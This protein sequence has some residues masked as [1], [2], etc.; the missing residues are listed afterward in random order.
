MERKRCRYLGY[1]GCIVGLV[2]CLATN[3]YDPAQY[4]LRH[5]L[6]LWLS[7][8]LHGTVEIGRLHGSLWQSLVLHDVVWRTDDSDIIARLPT[9]QLSYDLTALLSKRL[10][11]TQAVLSQPSVTLQQD[12]AGQWPVAVQRWLQHGTEQL[13]VTVQ[14]A[15]VSLQDGT[16]A[17]QR[18]TLPGVQRLT[19]VQG[20]LAGHVGP[21]GGAFHVQHLAMQAISDAVEPQTLQGQVQWHAGRIHVEGAVHTPGGG[22]TLHGEVDT[23]TTP[24]GYAGRLTMTHLDLSAWS[25]QP[26][27]RSDLNLQLQVAGAGD[28]LRTLRGTAH[29]DIQPSHLGEVILRP[30]QV[31][32]EVHDGRLQVHALHLDTSVVQGTVTGVLDTTGTSVLQY[33]CEADFQGL[34]ALLGLEALAGRV[35]LQGQIH[36]ARTAL[37][38]EGSLEAQQLQ[39]RQHGLQALQVTYG[40]TYLDGHPSLT[41]RLT[42]QR[43]TVAQTALGDLELALAYQGDTPQLQFVLDTALSPRARLHTQGS[44]SLA[45][46]EQRVV[47]KELAVHLAERTWR[48]VAPVELLQTAHEIRLSALRLTHAQETLECTGAFSVHALYDVTCRAAQLDVTFLGTFLPLPALMQGHLSASGHATGPWSA[49]R[50]RGDLTLRLPATVAGVYTEVEATGTYAPQQVRGVL[51]LRQEQR[52]VLTLAVTLPLALQPSA[53]AFQWHLLETPLALHMALHQPHVAALSSWVPGMAAVHGS[54]QGTLEVHGTPRA[55]TLQSSMDVLAL[56]VA[57]QVADVQTSVQAHA[58]FSLAT[59]R[60]GAGGVRVHAP[61]VSQIHA[62]QLRVAPGQGQLLSPDRSASVWQ[63]PELTLQAAGRLSA[64]QLEVTHLQVRSA[65]AEVRG[66]GVLTLP[67]YALQAHLQV[68]RLPLRML[69]QSLPATLPTV[70]QGEM[71]VRGSIA[72]PHVTLRLQYASAQIEGSLTL[73]RHA[74]LWRYTAALR[75]SHLPMALLWPDAAGSLRAASLRAAVHIEGTEGL[76]AQRRAAATIR[77]DVTDCP[78]LP[79]LTGQ[80]QV[81]LTGQTVQLVKATLQSVPFDIT[82]Q[83]TLTPATHVDVTYA[84]TLKDLTPLQHVLAHPGRAQG[85]LQ[86]TLQGAWQALRLQA[87]VQLTAWQYAAWQG[88]RLHA[89][90]AGS[91]TA[92]SPLTFQVQAV[93]I[94]GPGLPRSACRLTGSAT[95][96]QVTWQAVMTAGPYHKSQLA[97]RLALAPERRLTLSTLRLQRHNGVWTNT[98]PVHLVWRPDGSVD[99]QRVVLRHGPQEITASGLVRAA[100][101]VSLEVTGRRLQLGSMLQALM[102]EPPRLDGSVTLQLRVDGTFQQP[103]LTG[104]VQVTALQWQKQALGDIHGRLR[105]VGTTVHT[106]V[107]WHQGAQEFLSATGSVSVDTQ[108]ALMLRLRATD[109]DLRGA[110]SLLPAVVYSAGQVQ[111]DLRFEGTLPSPQIYGDLSVRDGVVQ[112]AA[113]GMRYHDI[114]V[115]LHVSGTRVDIQRGYIGAPQGFVELTGGAQLTGFVLHDLAVGLRVEAF[116]LL[117]TPSRE[118]V[119]SGQMALHG[120]LSELVASGALTVVHARTQ[121]T[122]KLGGGPA[123]IQPWQLTVEGVYGAGPPRT[124]EV[125]APP[126]RLSALL[127]TLRADLQVHMPRHVWIRGPGTAVELGGTL[128]VTKALD[129]PFLVRGTMKT[130]RGFA[131]FY[132]ERFAVAEG[133]VTFTGTEELRPDLDILALREVGDYLVAINV[134]GTTHTPQLRLSSIPSLP[135][136]DIVTLLAIGKTTDQL[137]NVE[138]TVLPSQTQQLTGDLATSERDTTL[139]KPL[140]LDTIDVQTGDKPGD[141][142]V[143][144]GRYVTQDVLLSYERQFGQE[145]GNRIGVEYSINRHLKLKGTTS[146][147]GPSALDMLWRIDY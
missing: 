143:S 46:T 114:H 87:R 20:H 1:L 99:L 21:A 42:G 97:G 121:L 112:I 3:P 40:G 72:A 86:G 75:L 113:T 57:G 109:I 98:A 96:Q 106:T 66:K 56:G 25:T 126:M 44:L 118:V 92:A 60:A 64:Q 58:T 31:H 68:P 4:V 117:Y 62:V 80:L 145:G 122:G 139:A 82:A 108:R 135:Q 136:A 48:A 81:L 65:D 131:N 37:T 16:I 77:L 91:L 9:V 88:Q 36:S 43:L 61:W 95:S 30:S 73:Q 52:E 104:E 107:R 53:T 50:L 24:W 35:R 70:L 90:V 47:L 105:T 130:L 18:P 147:V 41:A 129:A 22:L 89:D 45:A 33:V 26:A 63:W 19:T 100:G 128:V 67:Q 111:M 23:T 59:K 140:G 85:S 74:S 125:S 6:A 2:G 8:A 78:W 142:R 83:G 123:A 12:A 15:H 132:G 102:P 71:D 134:T 115:Q 110:K 146:D 116:P 32:L 76:A 7:H 137:S 101:P 14:L 13:P 54:L 17:L 144:V 93:D 5:S 28:G 127:S 141:T 138:R 120:S 27:L 49:P 133:Q 10:R 119:L 94:E 69:P 79:G 55:L 84:L 29:L 103:A 11:I 124:Q 38:V 39:Y 34:R 51:R